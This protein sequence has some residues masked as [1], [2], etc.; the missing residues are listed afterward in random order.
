MRDL[1]GARIQEPEGTGRLCPC[2]GYVLAYP[3]K[4][5]EKLV[6]DFVGDSSSISGFAY[7]CNGCG[8][9]FTSAELETLKS[10]YEHGMTNDSL[11]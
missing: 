6:R 7:K 4:E 9:T 1:I 11:D 10:L 5:S 3:K 2:S 8:R